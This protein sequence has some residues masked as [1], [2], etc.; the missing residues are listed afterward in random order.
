MLAK[1]TK[2]YDIAMQRSR[3]PRRNMREDPKIIQ[4]SK[5]LPA[6]RLTGAAI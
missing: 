3:R 2:I 1:K 6:R 4:V 5:G